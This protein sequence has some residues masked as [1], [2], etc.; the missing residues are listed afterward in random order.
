MG[1]ALGA[2]RNYSLFGD[3]EATV[4][5]ENLTT[6]SLSSRATQNDVNGVNLLAN[7]FPGGVRTA[8]LTLKSQ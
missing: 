2:A 3:E 5:I 6:R 7:S 4:L 1:V 8:W